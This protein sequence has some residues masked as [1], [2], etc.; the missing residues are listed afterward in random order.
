MKI[1]TFL[2][3]ALMG[4]ILGS[5][6]SKKQYNKVWKD[7]NQLDNNYNELQVKFDLM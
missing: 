6:V 1:R 5:C 7:Y 2:M 3:V 4:I